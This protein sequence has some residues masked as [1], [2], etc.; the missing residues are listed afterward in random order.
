MKRNLMLALVALVVLAACVAL[1]ACGG[2]GE[3]GEAKADGTTFVLGVGGPFTQ[4]D[5]AFGNGAKRAV[6]LAVKE[7]N[8]SDEAKELGIQFK[9]MEG[10]DQSKADKGVAAAS[11]F[12]SNRDLVG[13]VGHFNSAVSIPA[14]K[15]YNENNI[16][17]ISYGSTNPEL[18]NQG[19]ANVFRTC[20]TDALQGPAG[21]EYAISLG[22]KKVAIVDDSSVYGQGLTAAFEAKFVELGGEVVIQESTQQGQTDFAAVVTKIKAAGPDLVYFGGTYAADTGAG[23]LFTKQLKDGGVTVPLMGGDGIAEQPFI[24]EADGKAEGDLATLPGM[25]IEDLPQGA[26]FQAA[27]T[28]M[29]PGENPGG[30][31]AFAYDAANAIIKAVYAVAKAD[32]V[33]KVTSPAGREGII[34]A[35][36][37]SNF[38]GVTG[39]VSFDEKGDNQNPVIT[40]YEVKDGA[41]VA[42][43]PL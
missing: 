30:F 23:S 5:V 39:T 38:E 4:G 28:A 9:T 43:P 3:G 11:A 32:G 22:F 41:W 19:F 21:A 15:V 16:V 1:V 6:E 33:D 20:A 7:A 35:V 34:A 25:P 17:Q 13:V 40:T 12:V 31:D 36:A 37:A 24:D 14:S 2:G 27:Y 42:L 10:D 8:E 26:L 29:F 18:T